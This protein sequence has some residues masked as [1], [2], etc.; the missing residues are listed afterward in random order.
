M[1]AYKVYYAATNGETLQYIA[2][3][4]NSETEAIKRLC[5]DPLAPNN[6]V[7]KVKSCHRIEVAFTR[8]NSDVNG[9][10]RFVCHYVDL[11]RPEDDEKD[12]FKHYDIALANSR[13]F[14]GR[15]HHTKSYGGGI[16]FQSYNID[17]LERDILKFTGQLPE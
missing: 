15:K 3:N 2:K 16:A 5:A 14:G 6:V 13:Q 11:L 4:C 9:N 1:N 7:Q 10:P 17:G 12:V 8:I